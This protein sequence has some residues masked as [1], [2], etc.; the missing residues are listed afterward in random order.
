MPRL[1]RD[2]LGEGSCGWE[3]ALCPLL[4]VYY[5]SSFLLFIFRAFTLTY[6]VQYSNPCKGLVSVGTNKNPLKNLV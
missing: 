6:L 1:S 4:P 5:V 3:D 2:Y